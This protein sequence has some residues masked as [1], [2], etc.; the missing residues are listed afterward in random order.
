MLSSNWDICIISSPLKAQGSSWERRQNDCENWYSGYLSQNSVCWPGRVVAHIKPQWLWLHA[1][2]LHRINAAS[3]QHPWRRGLWESLA[4]E[5][6]FLKGVVIESLSLF[7][8]FLFLWQNIVTKENRRVFLGLWIQRV[9]VHDGREETAGG[10]NWMLTSWTTTR[11]QRES[12]LEMTWILKFSK[13]IPP[14][15]TL[16]PIRPHLLVLP[17]QHHWQGTRCSHARAYGVRS[18]SNVHTTHVQ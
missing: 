13:F 8:T 6:A 17:K 3:F 15:D 2:E 14:S 16:P 18:H 10:R 5:P 4:E 9:R 12:E 11:K 7:V 1:Q